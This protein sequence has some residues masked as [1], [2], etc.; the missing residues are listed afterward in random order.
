MNLP[1]RNFKN[2]DKRKVKRKLKR[3]V[4][5]RKND[6]VENLST[7]NQKIV[8]K[9]L[10]LISIVDQMN[11][12]YNA[13]DG[14]KNTRGNPIIYSLSG[15]TAVDASNTSYPNTLDELRGDLLVVGNNL[16]DLI[17][18][19]ETEKIIQTDPKEKWQDNFDFNLYIGNNQ[20]S[21]DNRMNMVFGK[22]IVE[23]ITKFIDEILE[24]VDDDV[25]TDWKRFLQENLGYTNGAEV[26]GGIY[27]QY[28][29]QKENILKNRFNDLFNKFFNQTFTLYKPFNID[30]KRVMD[31][32]TEAPTN[33]NNADNLINLGKN[34][35]GDKYNLKKKFK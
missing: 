22:D 2:G 12:I 20:N 19:L 13:T 30:K 28:K 15:T 9:E 16:N 4:D 21:Q 5:R 32:T 7:N 18:N 29:N 8:D 1:V 17:T 14:F 27:N 33:P 31:F 11:F 35:T 26:T 25:K 3:M 6:Y 10:L 24:A 34:S 23:D